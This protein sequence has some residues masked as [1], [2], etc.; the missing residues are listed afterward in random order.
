MEGLG[1]VPF[2]YWTSKGCPVE[3]NT[4]AFS[5]GSL[6][7]FALLTDSGSL[8]PRHPYGTP[9]GALLIE[10]TLVENIWSLEPY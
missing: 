2:G 10:Q 6:T 5:S 3:K 9:K 8:L 4:F 1:V 7:P